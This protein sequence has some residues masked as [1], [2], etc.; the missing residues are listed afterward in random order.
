[1]GSRHLPQNSLARVC[2]CVYQCVFV[3]LCVCMLACIHACMFVCLHALQVTK[4]LRGGEGR[5][6]PSRSVEAAIQ[7]TGIFAPERPSKHLISTWFSLGA[8]R[9]THFS[10]QPTSSAEAS[11][12]L[13]VGLFALL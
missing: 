11:F 8:G 4:Y 6:G 5:F 7:A 2:M 3:P 13:L 1:M 10:P 9:S 12:W